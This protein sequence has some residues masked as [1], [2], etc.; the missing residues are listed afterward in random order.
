MQIVIYVTEI[1]ILNQCT[2]VD[3]CILKHFVES[4]LRFEQHR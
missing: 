1:S 2:T 3:D 4:E